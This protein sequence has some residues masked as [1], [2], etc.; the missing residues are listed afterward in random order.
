MPVY[1]NKYRGNNY[2]S[3]RV[4]AD[5]IKLDHIPAEGLPVFRFETEDPAVPGSYRAGDFDLVVSLLQSEIS[6][7]G[8]SIRDFFLGEE[9]DFYYLVILKISGMTFSGFARQ[10]QVNADYTFTQNK[11]QV[12]LTCKDVLMEWAKRCEAASNATINFA[13]GEQLTFEEY[14]PR[15]FAGLTSTVVLIELPQKTYLERLRELYPNIQYCYA[16]GDY[17]NFITGQDNISRWETF[18]ELAKGLGFNFEM[19]VNE[20]TETTSEPEFIFKIFFIS[21][22]LEV[23][24]IEP[25]IIEMSESISPPRLNWLFLKYR[26]IV[27]SEGEYSDGIFFSKDEVFQSDTNHGDGVTLY[28]SCVLTFRGKSLSYINENQ[29]TEKRIIRDVDFTELPLKL[30][31]YDFN[32][33]VPI[34]K[35]YPLNEALGGGIAYARIFNCARVHN[36]EPDVYDY[37]PIQENSIIQYIN[38][39]Y[40][41]KLDLNIKIKLIENISLTKW[42]KIKINNYSYITNAL[43]NISLTNNIIDLQIS[44]FNNFNI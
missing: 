39:L 6:A 24:A 43:F 20:G 3:E 13:N 37:I 25:E 21:D 1:I 8:K 15:H 10:S 28:P 11:W 23:E 2:F 12:K 27:F 41:N 18:K 32:I 7:G 5:S 31:H 16:L 44:R 4:F 34:G 22:L 14:I 36:N 30:Y 17:R 35:L 42:N 29:I 26:S 9:R 38:T 19:Y 33:N 40:T